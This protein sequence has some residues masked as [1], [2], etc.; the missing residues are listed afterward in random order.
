MKTLHRRIALVAAILAVAVSALW[1]FTGATPALADDGPTKVTIKIADN[2]FQPA[3]VDVPL[4]A[5]VELTFVWDSPSHP[6]DEHIIVIP[7]YKLESEKIDRTNKQTVVKFVATKSGSFLFKCDMECDTH[8]ILQHGNI[9]VTAGGAAGAGAGGSASSLQ[10]SKLVI[11]PVKGIVVKGNTVNIA[12]SL[13]DKDGKPIAKAEVLFFADRQFLGRQGEVPIAVGKTDA[14]GLVFATYHPT[15]SDGG[16]LIARFEGGGLFDKT[17][18]AFNLAGSPQFQPVP[19]SATDDDLHGMKSVA[20]YALVGVIGGVW[21]AFAFML[22]Q[23][24]GI[25]RVRRAEGSQSH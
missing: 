21:L 20:P 16:K 8:D 11:D 19:Q 18:Q 13:Q 22:F 17:E 2:G 9:N 10:V 23:A 3:S 24:W 7:G 5:T 25:S 1:L 14:N 6:N 4:N 15:N 12:A